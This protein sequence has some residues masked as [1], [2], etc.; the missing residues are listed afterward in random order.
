ML[1]LIVLCDQLMAVVKG[2]ST[3]WP[4]IRRHTGTARNQSGHRAN[5]IPHFFFVQGRYQG[6]TDP[7]QI[8][9]C[10]YFNFEWEEN[11]G[12]LTNF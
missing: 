6:Q 3:K 7:I 12:A 1:F 4:P 9:R 5:G 8:Q 10:I 2:Q 11:G